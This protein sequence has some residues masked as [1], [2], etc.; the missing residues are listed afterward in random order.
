MSL[1]LSLS[2]VNWRCS[3]VLV[4]LLVFHGSEAFSRI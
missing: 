3:F 1:T 2:I 4:E